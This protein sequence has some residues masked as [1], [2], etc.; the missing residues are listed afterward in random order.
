MRKGIKR[1]SVLLVATGFLA[2]AYYLGSQCGSSI[3]IEPT[4]YDPS[5]LDPPVPIV[6]DLPLPAPPTAPHESKEPVPKNHPE[7]ASSISRRIRIL[8]VDA[9]PLQPKP[10][11]MIIPAVA[12]EKEPAKEADSQSLRDDDTP[13][14]AAR[15]RPLEEDEVAWHV[16]ETPGKKP[17]SGTGA[18]L[19][20]EPGASGHGDETGHETIK[21]EIIPSRVAVE[22]EARRQTPAL[23]H[24][25]NAIPATKAAPESSMLSQEKKP[26]V[27]P[28]PLMKAQKIEPIKSRLSASTTQ[29]APPPKIDPATAK[30]ESKKEISGPIQSSPASA[31]ATKSTMV[32][33]A[34]VATASVESSGVVKPSDVR[35]TPKEGLPQARP[36]KAKIIALLPLPSI[37]GTERTP[38]KAKIRDLE[39]KAVTAPV[40][41]LPPA[42]AQFTS[43]EPAHELSESKPKVK[44]LPPVSFKPRTDFVPIISTPEQRPSPL[45]RMSTPAIVPVVH[46]VQVPLEKTPEASTE[47]SKG[48]SPGE[49]FLPPAELPASVT[50]AASELATQKLISRSLNNSTGVAARLANASQGFSGSDGST[51]ILASARNGIESHLDDERSRST[52]GTVH[53]TATKEEIAAAAHLDYVAS[54][55]VILD[56]P[57]PA[58]TSSEV[59]PSAKEEMLKNAIRAACGVQVND[60]DVS[61]EKN[62]SLR[63]RLKAPRDAEPDLRQTILSL[64][65]LADY[66]VHLSIQVFP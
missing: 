27:D 5:D 45:P 53:L 35:M 9:A 18:S 52:T 23:S 4:P 41:S 66:K 15:R 6:E 34:P 28:V 30:Q 54:G 33:M 20:S 12:V 61:L 48:P 26:A 11:E 13:Q 14:P 46:K 1:G 62:H 39:P 36:R 44:I 25:P 60:L 38:P 49:V 50:S 40:V 65:A 3:P 37:V 63:I 22:P 21:S 51:L 55:V 58:I 24:R 56:A 42:G 19:F 10:N 59:T 64:P 29:V 43:T 16:V 7:P 8:S 2:L 32:S 31:T 47:K 17:S 57:E